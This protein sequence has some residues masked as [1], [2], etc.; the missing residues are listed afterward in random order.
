MEKNFNSWKL[1]NILL[2]KLVQR[3]SQS[4]LK[5]Q[6]NWMKKKERIY[7]T[8][9]CIAVEAILKGKLIA[10]NAFINAG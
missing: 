2:N 3:N 8:K 7:H 4:K 6:A 1:G 5:I 10:L 9:I